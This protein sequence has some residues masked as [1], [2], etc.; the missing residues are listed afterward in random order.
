MKQQVLGRRQRMVLNDLADRG[1]RFSS[2]FS[3]P[4]VLR[5]LEHRGLAEL[6]TG[7][8][9]EPSKSLWT[10][11]LAGYSWLIV[12]AALGMSQLTPGCPAHMKTAD[13]IHQL[14]VLSKLAASFGPVDWAG[15]GF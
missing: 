14:A 15:R 2:R 9:R 13:R 7:T 3:Y 8:V 1:G 10:I 12:D 4:E 11:T 5:T 6:R